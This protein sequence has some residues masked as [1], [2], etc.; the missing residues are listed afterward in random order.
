[1][2]DPRQILERNVTTGT[3]R[4]ACTGDNNDANI[5]IAAGVLECLGQ[6]ASHV[7]DECIQPVRTVQSDR[8][9]T[10]AFGD[11]NVFVHLT[12]PKLRLALVHISVQT[13][14]SI[15]RLEELLLQF[16]F[17]RER[18]FEGELR[19]RL[20]SALDATNGVRRFVWGR[21][22]AC[23]IIDHR[24]EAF[25]RFSF[26]DLIQNTELQSAFEIKQLSQ[27]H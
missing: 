12:S 17:Q 6:V 13:F 21:E 24:S 27:R 2:R 11:F 8:Q 4:T 15:F 20:D 14:F 7:P 22:L 23:V 25:A 18:R 16:A 5:A 26:E 19:T 10:V 9:D 3:E 1:M